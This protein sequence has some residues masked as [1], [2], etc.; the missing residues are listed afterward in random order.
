MSHSAH[1]YKRLTDNVNNNNSQTEGETTLV[2]ATAPA[3]TTRTFTRSRPGQPSLLRNV[4]LQT[5]SGQFC[6]DTKQASTQGHQ[7]VT[8]SDVAPGYECGV[9]DDRDATFQVGTATNA[10]FKEFMARPVAIQTYTWDVGSNINETFNPWRDLMANPR[11]S[12]RINN[13]YGLRANVKLRFLLN[14]G[15]FFYSRAMA[16]YF[17]LPGGNFYSTAQFSDLITASQRPHIFLDPTTSQGGDMHLP[18]FYPDNAIDL[19]NLSAVNGMGEIWLRSFLPLRHANATTGSVTVTVFAW[20]EDLQLVGPTQTNGELLIGQSGNDE[21]NKDGIISKPATIMKNISSRLADAP[22]IGPYMRATE[23]ATGAIASIARLFGYSRPRLVDNQTI[24]LPDYSGNMVNCNMTD[25]STSFGVDGKQE[26]TI[27]PRTVGLSAADELDINYLTGK[28]S[29]YRLINWTD[30]NAV[31]DILHEIPINPGSFYNKAS[32]DPGFLTPMAWLAQMFRYWNGTIK[33]RFQIC[34]AAVHKGRLAIEWDAIGDVTGALETNTTFTRIVDIA[35]ERD[36][37][38]EIA[39]GNYKPWLETWFILEADGNRDDTNPI[40]TLDNGGLRVRVLN[41]ITNPSGEAVNV[42]ILAFASSDDMAYRSPQSLELMSYFPLVQ[43]SGTADYDSAPAVEE[44]TEEPSKPEQD[45]VVTILGDH[46]VN[47]DTMDA[48]FF[49]ETI[50]TMR[51]LLKRYHGYL[52]RDWTT[53]TPS[54]VYWNFEGLNTFPRYKG[55]V[56]GTESRYDMTMITM[57]APAY[58]G[59][60]GAIRHKVVPQFLENNTL[61]GDSHEVIRLGFD[62]DIASQGVQQSTLFQPPSYNQNAKV[63]AAGIVSQPTAE[64]PY[65]HIEMPYYSSERF[66]DPQIGAYPPSPDSFQ[67]GRYLKG[68]GT[69]NA[70][71]RVRYFCAAGEDFNLF[72]FTGV[73]RIYFN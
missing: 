67:Y 43:Q 65:F 21:Y 14:G 18:F 3:L 50:R 28:E 44:K 58:R 35:E 13:F 73:P 4:Q 51:L 27:D 63:G 16:S 5:Q 69:D 70:N 36:F 38:I 55:V 48:I 10:D 1:V 9:N 11:I 6:Y 57:L 41:P 42:G 32:N 53:L 46:S 68:N 34:S 23:M 61:T 37:T 72:F 39:W 52:D 24:M 49:G 64:Q 66:F 26:V 62:L 19:T 12:N 40:K 31:D 47:L 45:K 30:S 7:I 29:F 60:R 20:F 8:Y 22:M 33:I 56:L 71:M 2:D 54:P 25:Y 15:P 17:P 59:W